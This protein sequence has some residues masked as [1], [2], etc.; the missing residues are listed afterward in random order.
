MLR[1]QARSSGG[2][3]GPVLE[4][5]F[6]VAG[7]P[8]V[9]V[10]SQ[11]RLPLPTGVAAM[12][13]SAPGATCYRYEWD[14]AA[15]DLSSES[16]GSGAAYTSS[17]RTNLTNGTHVLRVQG[18]TSGG[19]YGPVTSVPFSVGTQPPDTTITEQPSSPSNSSSATFGFSSSG[20]GTFE[21][22]LD[23]AAFTTCTSPTTLE[24]LTVGPHTFTVRA[25][26]LFG[27]PDPSPASVTWQVTNVAPNSPPSAT[28]SVDTADGATPLPV[29]F[30]L[31]A[32]D[33]DDD[34]LTW[35]FETGDGTATQTGT[36]MPPATVSH[37]YT[38]VGTFTARLTVDDGAATVVRT[39]TVSAA[40]AEPLNADA[41]DDRLV[42]PDEVVEFDGSNSRPV[43]GIDG[44]QWDFGDGATSTQE[45]P[46][47]TYSAPGT[48]TVRLTVGAGVAT[49]VDEATVTVSAPAV[50][51][52][53]FVTVR[54]GASNVSGADVLV[55]TS[56]GTRV[57]ALS[58]TDGVARLQG[59]PDGQVQVYVFAPGKRPVSTTASVTNGRGDVTVD[60]SDGAIGITSVE[61]RRLD[62]D[63]IVALGI[64]PND[65]DNQNIF[66][67]EAVLY[68]CDPTCADPI[69]FDISGAARAGGGGGG[70]VGSPGISC[71]DPARCGGVRII[72]GVSQSPVSEAPL[73][74]FLV[75][76]GKARFLKEFFEVKMLV[77]N[78]APA[79]ISLAD[80]AATLSLPTGLSLA[81]TAQEQTATQQVATIDGGATGQATWIVRGDV[82]GE[83]DL[84]AGYVGTLQPFGRSVALFAETAEPLKVW[85][86]SAL[87][88]TVQA[89]QF[90]TQYA[91]Y[92]VR[93]GLRN[94]SDIP[95]YNPSVELLEDGRFGYIYQ[96]R[97]QLEYGTAK[98]DPGQT[99]WTEQYVL[100]PW[101]PGGELD[102][103]RSFVRKTAGNVE[104]ASEII[105]QPS[106]TSRPDI[107]AEKRIGGGTVEF[108]P[109]PGAVAYEAY[110]TRNADTP[111]GPQPDV[112]FG[113]TPAGST[114]D[115]GATELELTED[116]VNN[117]EW[118][119]IST[120]FADG[121][122]RM[123]HPLTPLP[124]LASPVGTPDGYS[125]AKG[126]TLTVP[127]PGVL[128]N[129]TTVVGDALVAEVEEAP[130]VG[131]LDLDADGGFTY[132]PPPAFVGEQTFTYRAVSDGHRTLGADHRH[133]HG[134]RPARREHR[135]DR[136]AD[137]A[138]DGG[139]R[140][141]HRAARRVLV[142]RQRRRDRELCVGLR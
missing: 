82:E 7:G 55:M 118:V 89:D 110:T 10:W 63:E 28:L 34:E 85:G 11:P 102:L 79:G 96:A 114:N 50:D 8:F 53:L 115:G 113:T 39:T 80:G 108:D 111:N 33:P 78:L 31:G 37:T 51:S 60:L 18:R 17:V 106:P 116:G 56:E 90:L 92:R 123:V 65:P 138:A 84:S 76:P 6:T 35:R 125:V 23:A 128:G 136:R 131:T 77:A 70:I 141:A 9:S 100:M 101:I 59:L 81:P 26:D 29:T 42:A 5:V 107:S 64:D 2:S 22:S 124:G 127:A 52:G 21:C 30:T 137:R 119:G 24:G 134:D 61:S 58:G 48:Y 49:D 44:Y 135:T 19:S 91:P 13:W 74:N 38:R 45:R 120:L 86:G 3:Y 132:T 117:A 139:H 133:D 88:M 71:S 122:R 98:V 140:P 1:V 69:T 20:A 36:G 129:D 68:F 95:V 41:G 87:E 142:H 99:F 103:E 66:Q 105:T 46:N 43:V 67:F 109:I 16:C 126:T 15:D 104:L 62:L 72:P 14:G 47:H 40:L 97:Q 12:S 27:N 57:G 75:I 94:V 112:A 130:T 73:L 93:V 4:R 83:Y 25:I 121:T 32:S 54:S